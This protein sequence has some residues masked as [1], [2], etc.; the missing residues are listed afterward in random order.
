MERAGI[1]MMVD[2]QYLMKQDPEDQDAKLRSRLGYDLGENLH[3]LPED[4]MGLVKVAEL[5]EGV[6]FDELVGRLPFAYDPVAPLQPFFH[7]AEAGE[8]TTESVRTALRLF[9]KRGH[10]DEA[11]VALKYVMQGNIL[12]DSSFFDSFIRGLI[13]E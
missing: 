6:Y 12:L 11:I 1:S 3:L 5:P 2:P 9:R 4:P 13:Q 8:L 7:A 10:A